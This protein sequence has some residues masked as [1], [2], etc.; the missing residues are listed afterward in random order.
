MEEIV[1]ESLQELAN[2]FANQRYATAEGKLMWYLHAQ[3]AELLIKELAAKLTSKGV[4]L[5][6]H[7]VDPQEEVPGDELEGGFHVI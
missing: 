6:A 3:D 7:Q 5:S 1:K 4:Q 2:G